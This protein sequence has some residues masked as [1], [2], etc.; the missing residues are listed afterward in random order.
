MYK[1]GSKGR[2]VKGRVEP[3]WLRMKEIALRRG[4]PQ[5]FCSDGSLL[6]L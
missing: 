1:N 2:K 3:G 6:C 5:L 4:L